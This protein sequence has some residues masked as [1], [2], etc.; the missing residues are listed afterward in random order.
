MN[1]KKYSILMG[2]IVASRKAQ[3]DILLYKIFNNI[4]VKTNKKF[5]DLIISPL[6]IT[7]GDEFQGLTKNLKDSF[8]IANFLRTELLKKK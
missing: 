8:K 2:D 6:T 4:I 7:L 5:T 3:S 1:T